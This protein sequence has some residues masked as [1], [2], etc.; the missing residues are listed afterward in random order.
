MVG[1]AR[2]VDRT[3]RENAVKKFNELAERLGVDTV[4]V[5]AK[6][7]D[8]VALYKTLCKKVAPDMVEELLAA[9]EEYVS[10]GGTAELPE[11]LAQCAQERKTKQADALDQEIQGG[12]P[13]Q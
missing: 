4:P 9:R 7:D 1:T 10:H 6:I 3:A 12:G 2:D 8:V 5:R 11:E 13:G